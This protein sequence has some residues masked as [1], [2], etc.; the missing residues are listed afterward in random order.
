MPEQLAIRHKILIPL[1]TVLCSL[2]GN[3]DTELAAAKE[4]RVRVGDSFPE[5]KLNHLNSEK[6]FDQGILKNKMVVVDFWA[7]DCLPCREAVPELNTLFK[8]FRTK[9]TI[10]IGIN[11]DEDE[12]YTSSFLKEFKPLYTLLDDKKHQLISKMGVDSMPTTYL[13]DANGI[14]RFINRGFKTG[15]AQ[16]IRAEIQKLSSEKAPPRAKRK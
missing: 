9:N 11:A 10:F 5:I 7:S 12:G 3:C 6:V 2:T 4:T 8:E 16:K 13:L 15:D 1:F 14:V